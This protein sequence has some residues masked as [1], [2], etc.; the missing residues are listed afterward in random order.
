M[1]AYGAAKAAV[2]H[3]AQ[4]AAPSIAGRLCTLLPVV[5][6]TEANRQAMPDEDKDTWTPCPVIGEYKMGIIC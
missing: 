5:L 1:L 6:D 4:S 2:I 3:L